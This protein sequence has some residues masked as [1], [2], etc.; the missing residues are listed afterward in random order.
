MSMGGEH[1]LISLPSRD[2]ENHQLQQ[3][4]SLVFD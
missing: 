3:R 1:D 4:M 2:I